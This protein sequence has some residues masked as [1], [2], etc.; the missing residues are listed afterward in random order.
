MY[1]VL[2]AD[3]EAI[4]RSALKMMLENNISQ[5]EVTG[6]AENGVQLLQM[7]KKNRYDIAI[8]DIEMPGL[9]GL[10]V[11]QMAQKELEDTR[12]IIF[13]AYSNFD[14]A[15]MSLHFHAFDYLLK[16]T[17][18]DKL[19]VTIER[20]IEDIEATRK[21]AVNSERLKKIIEQIRP[22][23]DEELINSFC[24]GSGDFARLKIYLNALEISAEAGYMV[25]F[26]IR[27]RRKEQMSTEDSLDQL[28][29]KKSV[30]VKITS[31]LSNLAE[32]VLT[33]IRRDKVMAFIPVERPVTEYQNRV[34]SI[35]LIHIILERIKLP[36]TV[37]VTAGIGSLQE[38]L[39][40]MHLSYRESVSALY[41][42][43]TNMA[44]RHYNDLFD[45][46]EQDWNILQKEQKQ[47]L[48]AIR[49]EDIGRQNKVIEQIFFVLHKRPQEE[50]SSCIL[51]MMVQI[52]HDVDP[53]F[54]EDQDHRFQ[55]SRLCRE[56]MSIA[57]TEKLKQ[58]LTEYCQNLSL[59]MNVGSHTGIVIEKAKKYI[60]DNY[61]E[62]L[63]L[64]DV[65]RYCNVSIYYL[66]RLFKEKVGENYSV[67]L[68][69]VRMEA[70]KKMIIKYDYPLK[71]LADKCG[72]RSVGYF[73]RVFKQY[74]GV[75]VGEFKECR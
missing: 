54:S 45:K 70:A 11:L 64:N 2:I 25:T 51:E 69:R 28:A 34:D 62:D 63:S 35:N 43:K 38:S 59:E 3:D 42:T 48:E 31:E 20:C 14:Y 8:V 73:C 26:R 13:T 15:Q 52:L 72:F 44:I 22:L 30:A 21:G 74:T 23:M 12:V 47:L 66:S 1:Q 55:I 18:R 65:S 33:Q 19:M 10:E 16:P 61:Q 41:D 49:D 37:E 4:E 7:L 56:C 67:Y 39:E 24:S 50:C 75:T 60:D 17:R 40:Q 6:E 36:G 68:T 71:T 29:L 32:H 5:I 58:W 9:S 27:D 53:Y 46:K 57:D